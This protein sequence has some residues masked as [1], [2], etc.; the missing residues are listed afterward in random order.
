[1]LGTRNAV[2]KNGTIA[3]VWAYFFMIG[4]PLSGLIVVQG[5]PCTYL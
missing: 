5:M 4:S 2:T 1:M 3:I